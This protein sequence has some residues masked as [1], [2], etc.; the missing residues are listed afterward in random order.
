MAQETVAAAPPPAP[1]GSDEDVGPRE[2]DALRRMAV[3]AADTVN[4]DEIFALVCAAAGEL[5]GA[6][7][8][9]AAVPLFD[10]T[11]E[12]CA[13]QEP[14]REAGARLLDLL[15]RARATG[16][17]VV[18]GE[19]SADMLG[20]ADA[21]VVPPPYGAATAVA[22]PLAGEGAAGG[23]LLVGWHGARA[24]D[25]RAVRLAETLA[26]QAAAA[27]RNATRY[28]VLRQAAVRRERFFSAMSH[29]L[30][31][32]ITAI[33]G[34]SELL[35]DGIMG[36][37]EPHQQEMVERICQVSGHLA[38][39]VNDVLDIAKLDAGRM[40]FHREP[41]TLGEL[42]DEAVVAVEP[43]ARSK[44]LALRLDI[45]GD[46]EAVLEVDMGRV[47]QILVN[48]LSNAVKFTETGGVTLSV[49]VEDGRGWMRVADTGPGLPDGAEEAVFEEFM[50]IAAGTRAKREP[51]S[52]LGLA[53][54][55][56]LA[57]AMGGELTAANGEQ[58]GAVFTLHLP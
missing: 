29:D 46:R 14:P 9:M 10:G 34:Y 44:G 6:D 49:E 52:G 2:L 37:L 33:M 13:G 26:E 39:L 55:R 41:V 35:Q 47:R 32:P 3:A 27:F 19:L 18:A 4:G 38:Q 54:A 21:Q 11:R 48:L 1:A 57:R 5:L 51:G 28:D 40:E 17:V 20:L 50:Q 15:D 7:F 24:V 12:W 16:A 25:A 43:Q 8:A 42:V 58:G 45:D 30:R 36:D 53:I 31:T 23:A 56:R 22:A